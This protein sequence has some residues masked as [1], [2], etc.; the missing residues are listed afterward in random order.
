MGRPIRRRRPAKAILIGAVF[1]AVVASRYG[2]DLLRPPHV[3]SQ[4]ALLREGPCQVV[5]VVD[6]DTIVVRQSRSGQNNQKI[7][8]RLL[9]IDTPETV[10]PNHPV[11]PWGREA[12][13]FTKKFL[14]A[15]K[16]HVRLDRRRIDRYGRMLA[17]V[18]VG[19]MQL[20]EELVRAGLARVSLFPGDSASAARRLKQAE[21]EAKNAHR[22]IWRETRN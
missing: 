13:A 16:A 18:S 2:Y 20:N 7:R 10:K 1:L 8:V 22:G 14:V 6:G 17:Y 21:Q 3:S 12:T 5:R 15:E 9:G 4:D 19:E 11:E